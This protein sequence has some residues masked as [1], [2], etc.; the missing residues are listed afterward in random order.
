MYP[1]IR[2]ALTLV[3][4][5]NTPPI[6]MDEV[7][8]THTRIWPWDLDIFL[9]LNNGRVLTLMD[10]GR[11]GYFARN[12]IPKKLKEKGWF[13]TVAG[14][15]VRYQRRITVMQKLE[16]RTRL[17]GWDDRF[18]YFDQSFWR[19]SECCAQAV[20]RTAITSGRGIVPTIEVADALGYPSE[21]PPL[22]DWVT[23]WADAERQR[24][25]PPS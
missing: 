11:L 9:E 25:W 20:V 15:S 5:R 4:N 22:P 14:S 2:T 17:L 3:Q 24:T 13:G 16:L 10:L 18:T 7:H 19:G 6:G 12:D 23:A 21:S 1:L 8:I